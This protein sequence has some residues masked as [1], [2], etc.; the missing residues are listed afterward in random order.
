[1]GKH[2]T[3]EEVAAARAEIETKRAERL[4]GRQAK[5][6]SVYNVP[7][8]GGC[9]KG[10]R[11]A[12]TARKLAKA[13]K[14]Q[15]ERS[16]KARAASIANVNASQTAAYQAEVASIQFEMKDRRSKLREVERWQ[17][18]VMYLCG[19][20]IDEIDSKIGANERRGPINR[21]VTKG[22]L[23]AVRKSTQ[24]INRLADL[25]SKAP[26]GMDGF[27]LY[28]A[29]QGS[30]R[31]LHRHLQAA[32]D[33]KPEFQPMK[34]KLR[35]GVERIWN[36]NASALHAE[37]SAGGI[38]E[39]CLQAGVWLSV[40]FGR[41]GVGGMK[42]FDPTREFVDGG[43][44]SDA[45]ESSIDA[46]KIQ[47]RIKEHVLAAFRPD[48]TAEWRWLTLDHVVRLDRSLR[49]LDLPAGLGSPS[50]FLNEALQ[51]VAI[52]RNMAPSGIRSRRPGSTLDEAYR[53]AGRL[54]L[55]AIR[56]HYVLRADNA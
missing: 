37:A 32:L 50:K 45:A 51:E 33:T 11:R 17:V 56:A 3:P 38:E 25:A 16:Q 54:E 27:A 14:A 9:S 44:A 39:Y 41:I 8:L 5:C 21:I 35:G 19:F 23:E 10:C 48:G 20:T 47:A 40:L 52:A 26:H 13:K 36:P 15:R 6:A 30:P 29:A 7:C 2:R 43:G 55:E 24:R 28:W 4:A 18:S 34:Q 22:K 49:T 53:E 31:G 12:A 46:I 1:V 42:G